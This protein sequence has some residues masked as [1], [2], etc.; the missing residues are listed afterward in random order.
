MGAI[1]NVKKIR[2]RSLKEIEDPLLF[3]PKRKKVK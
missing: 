1:A 2:I 3:I